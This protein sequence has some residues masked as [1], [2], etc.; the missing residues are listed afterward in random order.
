MTTELLEYS[1]RKSETRT[2]ELRTPA[3][4]LF[5]VLTLAEDIAAEPDGS[6]AKRFARQIIDHCELEDMENVRQTAQL[7]RETVAPDERLRL[8]EAIVTEMETMIAARE[9]EMTSLS[10]PA[11]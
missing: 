9:P 5:D 6:Q 8:A 7:I 1:P 4:D 11:A 2:E 3:L 10:A